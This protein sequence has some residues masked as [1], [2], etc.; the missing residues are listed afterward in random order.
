M[1]FK[2]MFSEQPTVDISVLKVKGRKVTKS[3][4]NQMEATKSYLPDSP[5]FSDLKIIGYVN[6]S[7]P[8]PWMIIE[9]DGRLFKSDLS[10][11][12]KLISS[13]TVR[14]AYDFV[15]IDLEPEIDMDDH[16]SKLPENTLIQFQSMQDIARLHLA[17][18]K[19][20]QI[21]I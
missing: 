13:K 12:L 21:Y 7:D 5:F 9:K 18:L 3:L 2:N 8:F 16:I 4:L 14:D 1:D 20:H 17:I 19:S 6:S 15:D 10:R 11:L